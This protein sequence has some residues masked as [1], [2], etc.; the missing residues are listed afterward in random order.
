MPLRLRIVLAGAL[1]CLLLTVIGRV[2]RPWLEVSNA[3]PWK[4]AAVFAVMMTALLAF[5]ETHPFP[6]LGPANR[7][8]IIRALLV[9]LTAALIGEPV[10]PRVAG[11][12]VAAGTVVALLDGVD[13]WL[14]RRSRMASAFGGRFDMETDALLIMVLSVLVWQHDKAGAWILAAGLMR[15]AFVAAGWM[16]PWMAGPLTP[17]RR[18]KTVAVLSLVGLSLAL[19]PFVAPPLSTLV[20]GMT[21][22]SLMWSF[23]VDVRR[24]WRQRT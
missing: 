1:G 16:L 14:A 3:Y 19:A 22:A 8:T 23:A 9:T 21:L 4:A 18:A 11:A 7:V 6:R 17:T 10:T 13:G 2:A 15:Y 12:A 20:A 5:V 24:L